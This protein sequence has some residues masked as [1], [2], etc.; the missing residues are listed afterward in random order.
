L[1]IVFKYLA[2][3]HQE[4]KHIMVFKNILKLQKIIISINSLLKGKIDL[5]IHLVNEWFINTLLS[6]YPKVLER[7]GISSVT[8]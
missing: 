7:V 4:L 5:T 6:Y 3:D 2:Q 8:E 1:K